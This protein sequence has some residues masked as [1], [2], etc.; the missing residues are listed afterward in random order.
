MVAIEAIDS[1]GLHMPPALALEAITKDSNNSDMHQG[2]QLQHQRAMGSN[3]ERLEFLG[4]CFL[5]MATSISL[6][7][8]YPEDNEEESHVKRML[9]ISNGNLHRVALQKRL[10]EYIRSIAF[11]RFVDSQY[12]LGTT[13]L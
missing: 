10:Y 4:D 12:V 9:M 2:E 13:R 1:L 6:F 11:S 7:T 3:Y 5:K 8:R